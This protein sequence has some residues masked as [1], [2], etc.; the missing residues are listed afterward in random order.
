MLGYLKNPEK[1]AETIVDGW[2]H[3]GD[4]GRV[5]PNGTL[6]IIDRKKNLFKTSFGEYIA[7]EKVEA[8]YQKAAAVNQ[9]W[10]TIIP[11]TKFRIAKDIFRKTE[12]SLL[13]STKIL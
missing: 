8:A 3:T 5:N 7:V 9:I 2:L 6:S 10:V 11:E 13:F 1:T 4:V 12:P